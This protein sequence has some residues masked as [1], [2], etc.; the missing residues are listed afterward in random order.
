M[1]R[2]KLS[3]SCGINYVDIQKIYIDFRVFQCASPQIQ[4]FLK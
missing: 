1:D 3:L 4:L 2:Y